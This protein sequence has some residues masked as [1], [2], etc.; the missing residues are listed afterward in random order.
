MK[1]CETCGSEI[2]TRDGENQCSI[3]ERIETMKAET[4][5]AANKRASL[6]RRE[7]DDVMSSLGL[8]KVRGSMGGVYWE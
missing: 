8:T 3:C 4:R 2:S 7:R 6:R 1:V 5:K